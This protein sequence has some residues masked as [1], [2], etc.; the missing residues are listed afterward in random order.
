MEAST[1]KNGTFNEVVKHEF[2]HNMGMKHSS[3]DKGLMRAQG[4]GQTSV[5][6]N[7]R[8]EIVSGAIG[9]Q[10]QVKTYSGGYSISSVNEAK[11]F[12]QNNITR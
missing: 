6:P 5:T 4:T 7:Q 12:K 10:K 2:G 3:N 11:K 9:A 8:G 1:I